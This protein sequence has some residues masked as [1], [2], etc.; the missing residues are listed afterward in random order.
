MDRAAAAGQAF[1]RLDELTPE[2]IG[3]DTDEFAPVPYLRFDETAQSVFNES[4]QAPAL[5]YGTAHIQLCR[6]PNRS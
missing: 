5:N 2:A 1:Q 6:P 3:A 4:K